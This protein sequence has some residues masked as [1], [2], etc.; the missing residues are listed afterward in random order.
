[1]TNEI[2]F[3]PQFILPIL[4]G[5]KTQ[6]T[7]IHDRFG[8]VGDFLTVDGGE[9]YG[10]RLQ[11]TGKCKKHL[12]NLNFIEINQEGFITLQKFMEFWDSLYGGTVWRSQNNPEVIIIDFKII[13]R[14]FDRQW[15]ERIRSEKGLF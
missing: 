14:W 5:R 7:R 1:M 4:E 11:I 6:T 2:E 3:A 10:L 9:C 8:D 13:L 12:K 15:M